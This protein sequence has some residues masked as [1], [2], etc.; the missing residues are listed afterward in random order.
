MARVT[1]SSKGRC[2]E[3]FERMTDVMPAL[4]LEK[5]RFERSSPYLSAVLPRPRLHTVGDR[6]I[7]ARAGRVNQSSFSEGVFQK[8]PADS[9]RGVRGRKGPAQDRHHPLRRGGRDRDHRR[10]AVENV[11]RL[12]IAVS[13]VRRLTPMDFSAAAPTSS[14]QG[15]SDGDDVAIAPS[16]GLRMC[17]KPCDER[18]A[19]AARLRGLP[20]R[21]TFDYETQEGPDHRSNH[22]RSRMSSLWAWRSRSRNRSVVSSFRAK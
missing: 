12:H 10:L 20:P 22:F 18:Q 21:P 9:R 13:Q 8:D 2:L 7:P 11:E 6:W 16:V 14:S 3:P 4:Y 15:N 19:T 1:L 17:L 5:S